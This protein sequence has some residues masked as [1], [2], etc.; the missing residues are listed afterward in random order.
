MSDG[1]SVNRSQYA[2]TVLR[3]FKVHDLSGGYTESE[4]VHLVNEKSE[5]DL[6]QFRSLQGCGR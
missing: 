2:L 5:H 6:F 3:A 4:I 1:E